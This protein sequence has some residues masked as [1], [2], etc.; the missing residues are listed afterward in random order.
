MKTSV[1]LSLPLVAC[2]LAVTLAGSPQ[3]SHE[4]DLKSPIAA[5]RLHA[6]RSLSKS[7]GESSAS[8]LIESLSDSE[9]S[10]RREAAKVLGVI[11]VPKA[12][13]ALIAALNDSDSNVRMY[14]AYALGEIKAAD[15]VERLLA[16]LN[17]SE[18]CVRDQ[19]AW[20]LREIGSE[21]IIEPLVAT[22]QSPK[23]D[24]E[25]VLWILKSFDADK[26]TKHFARLL[27]NPK[28]TT[29]L[30]AI[31][32]LAKMQTPETFGPLTRALTDSDL[33]IRR[34]AVEILDGQ[35]DRRAKEPLLTLAAREEDPA[36]RAF[37]KEVA[38]ELSMHE[39]LDAYWNFDDSTD[40][41]AKDMTRHGNDGEIRGA[42]PVDG[43]K[44]QA[45]RFGP[46]KYVELGKAPALPI[47]NQPFTV[48]AWIR[49]EAPTGVVVARGGA[50]CGYSLYLLDGVP[51]F[52]IHREQ[53]GPTYIAAGEQTL[54]NSWRHLAGVVAKDRIELYVDG[55]LAAT[56]EIP[57]YLP[58]NCGQGMEIGFDVS[59][60]PAEI[61]DSF[62]GIID[63]VKAFRTAISAEEIAEEA[64]LRD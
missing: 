21:S 51:K 39:D 57:D 5:V 64:G 58:S 42:I 10:V 48:M 47:A 28:P 53:D 59:N 55:K 16:A 60:S 6:I 4:Q 11:K 36:L 14:A 31:R 12:T 62:Q 30:R 32:A 38:F 54:D 44:G 3:D 2:I 46:G 27:K 34:A 63:E 40:S 26:T 13:P 22:L 17:D 1:Y 9:A 25:Q 37:A 18:W 35:G 52:G 20:A 29:R 43:K 41:V 61:V 56:T 24:V 19:A 50:F 8:A 15:A 45:L 7:G 33:R 49:S 23:A